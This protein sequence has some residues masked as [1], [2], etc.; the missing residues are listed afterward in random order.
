[1]LTP[2]SLPACLKIGEC[3]TICLRARTVTLHVCACS[4][5]RPTRWSRCPAEPRV[6]PT[7]VCATVGSPV[8]PPAC[9]CSCVHPCMGEHVHRGCVQL[10]VQTRRCAF[11]CGVAR[12]CAQCTCLCVH[13]HTSVWAVGY[14]HVC[15]RAWEPHC[16]S[17]HGSVWVGSVP[18]GWHVLSPGT[19]RWCPTSMSPF[20]DPNLHPVEGRGRGAWGGNDALCGVMTLPGAGPWVFGLSS[21]AKPLTS[22]PPQPG[23]G[24]SHGD[25]CQCQCCLLR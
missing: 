18:V 15:T 12:V 23:E 14:T 2:S 17:G 11:T 8:H 3:G 10:G 22:S 1:M 13:M 7:P 24:D 21:Q 19:T 5:T 25:T 20:E 6:H 9:A 4:H 16:V